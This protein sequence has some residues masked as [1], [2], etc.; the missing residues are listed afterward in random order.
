MRKKG[1]GIILIEDNKVVLVRAGEK[2]L[3]L[4]DTV[5]LPGG[6]VEWDETEEQAAR[7][8]F[9][10][11]TGLIAGALEEFPGN[12][13]EDMIV[14]KDGKIEFSFRVFLAH[15]HSGQLRL[16][17][18]EEEPFWAKI[19]EARQMK[20]WANNNLLLENALNY[21]DNVRKEKP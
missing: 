16:G 21:L 3:H 15:S 8:E 11:E 2:S 12:Y 5:A 1:A 18:G 10:E 9:T 6:H 14:R 13:I 7:R 19:E 4:N 17:S 20:L